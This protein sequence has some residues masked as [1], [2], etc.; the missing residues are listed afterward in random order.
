MENEI[1]P[2]IKATDRDSRLNAG[3]RS[4]EKEKDDSGVKLPEKDLVMKRPPAGH[5][6]D[7]SRK[8]EETDS[9]EMNQH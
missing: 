9:S 6:P 4:D 2:T 1:V 3:N 7:P 5:A 8:Q